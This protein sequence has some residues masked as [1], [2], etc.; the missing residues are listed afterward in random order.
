MNSLILLPLRLQTGLEDAAYHRVKG[1]YSLIIPSGES[2]MSCEVPQTVCP[3]DVK[4]HSY[5]NGR[6][7]CS[8]HVPPCT[9]QAQRSVRLVWPVRG[10]TV[11]TV[12]FILQ[13]LLASVTVL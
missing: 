6:S 4:L 11:A 9:C 10:T 8:A 12:T 2:V 13:D 5:Q 7:S 3:G 1:E